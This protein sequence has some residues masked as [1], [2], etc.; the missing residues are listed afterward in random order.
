MPELLA[1]TKAFQARR[2]H[3]RAL[4]EKAISRAYNVPGSER[5]VRRKGGSRRRVSGP[6]S[7]VTMIP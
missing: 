5:E 4:V 7:D 6:E 1:I 2:I 3:A